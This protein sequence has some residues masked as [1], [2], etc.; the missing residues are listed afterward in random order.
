MARLAYGSMPEVGSSRM[1]ISDPPTRAMPTLL[2]VGV[3]V[4]ACQ[5]AC[6]L[7]CMCVPQFSLHSS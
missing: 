6:V 3:G 2:C 5:Y 4:F 1:T 7:V